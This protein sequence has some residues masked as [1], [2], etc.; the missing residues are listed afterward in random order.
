MQAVG[1]IRK[2]SRTHDALRPFVTECRY[3]YLYL[4]D[5][6]VEFL[7]TLYNGDN[8]EVEEY[9]EAATAL[10][11]L[12]K[13]YLIKSKYRFPDRTPELQPELTSRGRYYV[14]HYILN[15]DREPMKGN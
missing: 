6:Q 4:T 7:L 10:N 12:V 1:R 13:H 15:P 8:I 9:I 14:E 3:L 2:T 11:G 5:R